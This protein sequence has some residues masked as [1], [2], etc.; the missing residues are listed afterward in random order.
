VDKYVHP[1]GLGSWRINLLSERIPNP[2]DG[3]AYCEAMPEY[4]QAKV[5]IDPEQLETGEQLSE[6]VSHELTHCLT[7]PIETVADTLGTALCNALSE[8][9]QKPFAHV[10]LEYIREATE[11]TATNIGF[12]FH[13]YQTQ[14]DAQQEEIDQLKRALREARRATRGS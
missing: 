8:E 1:L 12:V 6:L 10:L 13:R 2:N 14:I 7:C 4:Q 5:V 9:M 11:R 3:R